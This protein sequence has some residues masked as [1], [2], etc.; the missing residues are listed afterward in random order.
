MGRNHRKYQSFKIM[1]FSYL[2]LFSVVI[3]LF[4]CS[5]QAYYN[6][7]PYSNF[8]PYNYFDLSFTFCLTGSKIRC[9]LKNVFLLVTICSQSFFPQAYILK[10]I[11]PDCMSVLNCLNLKICVHFLFFF[12]IL[13]I[14][15]P[16]L[17]N[18]SSRLLY[19]HVI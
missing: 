2:T 6:P 3:F 5:V 9:I 19:F 14:Y 13:Y 18:H 12:M 7:F 15:L 16:I 10:F 11:L 1:I 17:Y 8:L 4:Y